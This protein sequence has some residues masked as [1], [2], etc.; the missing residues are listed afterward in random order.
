MCFS[1]HF[2]RSKRFLTRRFTFFISWRCVND[3]VVD[4]N[5]KQNLVL[6]RLSEIRSMEIMR[7]NAKYE[8]K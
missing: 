1:L 4:D 8:Y 2:L 6:Y 3:F 5:K 7:Y